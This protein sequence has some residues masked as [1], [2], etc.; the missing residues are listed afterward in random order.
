MILRS[1]VDVVVVVIVVVVVV[2]VVVLVS[3]VVLVTAAT[4][5]GYIVNDD[6]DFVDNYQVDKRVLTMVLHLFLLG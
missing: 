2:A 1:F 5:V 6:N 3:V 4:V